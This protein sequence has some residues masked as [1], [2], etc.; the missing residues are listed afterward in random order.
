MG[1]IPARAGSFV[2]IKKE[3]EKL[4]EELQR[5]VA[6][7]AFEEAAELRDKIRKLEGKLPFRGD[8]HE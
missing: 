6:E 8:N 3:V 4:R 7:E 2:R 5:K 1:K